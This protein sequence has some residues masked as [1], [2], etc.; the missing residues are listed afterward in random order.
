MIGAIRRP[1]L[2]SADIFSCDLHQKLINLPRYT[3]GIVT[4]IQSALPTGPGRAE[5][6]QGQT[7]QCQ[8]LDIFHL[9]ERST[10]L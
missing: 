6:P 1:S 4:M 7:R 3:D 9:P 5:M 2:A 8:G 10:T